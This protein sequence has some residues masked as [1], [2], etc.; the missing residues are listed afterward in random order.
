L[1]HPSSCPL[2]S[3]KAKDWKKRSADSNCEK[4]NEKNIDGKRKRKMKNLKKKKNYKTHRMRV[5]EIS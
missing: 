1:T 3:L 5:C 4:E 2:R